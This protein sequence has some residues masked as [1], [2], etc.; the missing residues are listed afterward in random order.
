MPGPS[1]AFVPTLQYYLAQVFVPCEW[2]ALM[3]PESLVPHRVHPPLEC[4][5]ALGF[6][7]LMKVIPNWGG[8]APPLWLLYVLQ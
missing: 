3:S 2:W 7:H 4:P 5:P 6:Y 1:P 8:T